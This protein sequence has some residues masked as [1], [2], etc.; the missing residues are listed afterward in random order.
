MNEGPVV[1]RDE[2]RKHVD[3]RLSRLIEFL[4]RPTPVR[5]DSDIERLLTANALIK[6]HERK[7]PLSQECKP[8]R[9]ISRK[10]PIERRADL[11]R[12]R[13]DLT[14][15][16][17]TEFTPMGSLPLLIKNQPPIWRPMKRPAKSKYIHEFV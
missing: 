1:K 4:H 2:I 5:L 11:G 7:L 14:R 16:V 12:R 13:H 17:T 3:L 6:T 8:I 10:E 9:R 15:V